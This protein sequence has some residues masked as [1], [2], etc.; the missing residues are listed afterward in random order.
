MW[1]FSRYGFFSV[2]VAR[3]NDGKSL[4]Q[5]TVVVRARDRRHLENLKRAFPDQLEPY[6]IQWTPDRDYQCRLVCHRGTWLEV[7]V[8]IAEDVDYDNFKDAAGV[9]NGKW[10]RYVNTLHSIWGV[11]HGIA[12]RDRLGLKKGARHA[13]KGRQRRRPLSGQSKRKT[14]HRQGRQDS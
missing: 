14:R 8:G 3:A 5:S 6:S 9:T 7:L 1:V 4:K 11:A 10:S 13:S 2:T 12:P